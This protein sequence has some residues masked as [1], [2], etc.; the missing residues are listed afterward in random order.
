MIWLSPEFQIADAEREAIPRGP[1]E[2]S[3]NVY[4]RIVKIDTSKKTL[5]RTI[6]IEQCHSGEQ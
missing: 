5:Y 6:Q 2:A 4:I 3:L 1:L